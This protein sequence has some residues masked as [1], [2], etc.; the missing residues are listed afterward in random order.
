MYIY[1]VKS[2]AKVMKIWHESRELTR[3][4]GVND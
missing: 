2:V 3:K 1:N 4:N